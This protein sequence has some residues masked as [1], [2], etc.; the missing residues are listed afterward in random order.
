M[1]SM[2]ASGIFDATRSNC[3]V[4]YAM[5]PLRATWLRAVGRVRAHDGGDAGH[6]GDVGEELLPSAPAPRGVVATPT[7]VREDDLALVAGPGREPGL[8]QRRGAGDSVSV[9]E[10]PWENEAPTLEPITLTATR[11]T[12]HSTTTLR[13][14]R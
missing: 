6:L 10:N 7:R 11:A 4:A 9:R 5:S 2:V 14:R 3:T 12:I 1:C 8:E 13:R